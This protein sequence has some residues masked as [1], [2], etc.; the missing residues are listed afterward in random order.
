MDFETRYTDEEEREREALRAEVRAWL[1]DHVAGVGA[2]VDAADLSYEQ[3]QRNRAFL[4]ALGERGWYAPTWPKEFGGGG[5]AQ[6]VAAVIREEMEAS[7]PHLDNVHPPGDIG[8]SA[9]GSLWQVG[10]DE[11][12]QRFLP[13]ILRGEVITWE[14]YTEPE[15]G[16]DLP[17]L[18]TRAERQGDAYVLNGTKTLVGGHFEA[19]YLE[20]LAI[21]DP[22][23]PR[24]DNLSAFLVPSGLPGIVMTDMEMIAG[25]KKRTIIFEDARVPADHM[26]GREGEGWT[27]FTTGLM[28][29]LTVGIGPGMDRD[30][31]VVAQL[32]DYCRRE[33]GGRPEAQDA[34]ARVYVDFQVQRLFR[35]RNEWMAS[36]GQRTT[37]E[38]SQVSLGRKLFDLK[39]GEAI[40]Q[41]LGPLALISDP[42]WA[43][44][45]GDLEYFH[46]YAILMAHPGG[47]VEIQKLRMFRGMTGGEAG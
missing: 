8:G 12:K 30:E 43:P 15:A 33:L 23:A 6:H 21:T 45:E 2:P 37:Y 36:T 28:G 47:T 35:L 16:S 19:D 31:R 20:T 5:L 3:F 17:A 44:F 34:V 7:I 4:R 10:T 14:L 40:H 38:G 27:A 22:N 39:L 26:I 13:P 29:A 46:R 32:L 1:R 42:A 11:Q 18:K 41:A 25:S 9:A 24:R